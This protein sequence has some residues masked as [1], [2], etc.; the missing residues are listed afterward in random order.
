MNDFLLSNMIFHTLATIALLLYAATSALH[1]PFR[2]GATLVSR[3]ISPAPE[4]SSPARQEIICFPRE[5]GLDRDLELA[6]AA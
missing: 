2:R 6:E 3:V 5:H 4:P 1:V